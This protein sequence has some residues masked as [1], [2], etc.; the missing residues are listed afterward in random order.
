[1]NFIF[2]DDAYLLQINQEYL[3]HDTYTDIITFDNAEK[4]GVLESDIFISVERVKE[5]AQN[6]QIDFEQELRRVLIHG[7][8]HLLGYK[9]KNKTQEQEMRAKEDEALLWWQNL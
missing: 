8:L 5:N 9:D 7:V 6:L 2:C 1:M 3:N 4:K